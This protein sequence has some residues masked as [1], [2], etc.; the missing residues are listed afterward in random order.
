M[1]K[2][3]RPV[4]QNLGTVAFRPGPE[5]DA[6]DLESALIPLEETAR[7]AVDATI[8]ALEASQEEVSETRAYAP[9]IFNNFA[10]IG[11]ASANYDGNGHYT[12]VRPTATGI[13]ELNGADE[14]L[15]AGPAVVYGGLDF[16]SGINRC[17][18]GSTQKISG[19]VPGA[20]PPPQS[21]PFL[22]GGKLDP[23]CDES[24]VPGDNP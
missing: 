7:P 6:S 13:Y 9:D 15:P 24:Q 14:I 10:K 20:P 2:R 4:F 11:A 16:V 18:G 8:A 21:N 19:P 12:R 17:P 1:L 3:A 5:N 23:K 22:D